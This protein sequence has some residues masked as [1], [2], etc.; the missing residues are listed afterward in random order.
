[1]SNS[2]SGAP[3]AERALNQP[4]G[5]NVMPR[6]AG[7]ATMFRLPAETS[8]RGIDVAI[9]GVPLDIGTSNR[10]GARFGPRQIRSESALIRPYGMATRAAPFESFQ[11]ADLGDVPLNAYH[12]PK[13][14]EIIEKFYDTLLEH[15][16]KTLSMGGDHTIALPILR[17]L[18][19]KHGKM[20]LIHV[21]A[22]AD[23]NDEMFGEKIAHGTIFRRA[24]EEGLVDGHKMYQIGLRGTGYSA[25]DFDWAR[26]QGAV[27]VEAG[28]CWHRSLDPLMVEVRERVGPDVPT[29]LSFDI[30]GLDPSVAPGTGTPEIAGLTAAQGVE[31][32]RGAFGT[33]LVGA[34][35]VEVSPP[36]DTSGNTSLL[37]A[38]LLFEML[39]SFP[40]CK[41]HP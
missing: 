10:G 19:R 20:A 32:I 11:V 36:Y 37:A 26:G 3:P 33:N 13:S 24:L 23:V 40:G 8:A 9:V 1:M 38:N 6:F 18:H 22:H 39:C 2:K 5:G 27:V 12:L 16:V 14:I 35:L 25:E 34:D 41:R 30:D 7:P 31:I 15:D 29:Y 17:A 28:A 4:L 21:D